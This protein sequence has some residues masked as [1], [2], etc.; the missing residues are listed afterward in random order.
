V[1]NHGVDKTGQNETVTKVRSHLATFG[2]GTRDDCYSGGAKGVLEEDKCGVDIS[3]QEELIAPAKRPGFLIVAVGN[4]KAKEAKGETGTTGIQQ[5]LDHLPREELARKTGMY[6]H[7]KRLGCF[8]NY[9]CD[10][11]V[12]T[13]NTGSRC[14]WHVVL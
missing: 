10:P 11:Q 14:L 8:G 5:V 12:G 13:A 3:R 9:V 7:K 2:Q 1:N 4:S 6:V